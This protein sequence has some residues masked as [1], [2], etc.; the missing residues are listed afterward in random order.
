LS[1]CPFWAPTTRGAPATRSRTLAASSTTC[2]RTRSV[3]PA[4]PASRAKA[5]AGR[6]QAIELVDDSLLPSGGLFRRVRGQIVKEEGTQLRA[7][8]CGGDAA[9]GARGP[10]IW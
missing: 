2:M 8:A 7:Q 4:S 6:R 10:D 5:R 9:P 3:V 1:A